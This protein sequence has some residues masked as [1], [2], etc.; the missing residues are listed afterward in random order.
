VIEDVRIPVEDSFDLHS[1]LARDVAS[2]LAEYLEQ[3]CRKG[4]REVRV[5][6]GKG[7]GVRRIQVR[8][9]LSANPLVADFFDAPPDRG[10][11]GATIVLL[12]TQSQIRN[13]QSPIA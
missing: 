9:L 7:S 13:R 5:I 1:F 11:F 10:G 2:V 8:T 3:A 12:A 4:L 6:H